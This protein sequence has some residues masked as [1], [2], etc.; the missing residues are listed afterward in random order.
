MFST[1]TAFITKIMT[2]NYYEPLAHDSTNKRKL[3]AFNRTELG[4]AERTVHKWL[5]VPRI[6]C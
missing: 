4:I 6:S 1:E 3:P 2:N 5:S